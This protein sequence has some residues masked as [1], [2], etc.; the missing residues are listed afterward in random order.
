MAALFVLLLI[1]CGYDYKCRRIPNRLLAIM[2]LTCLGRSLWLAGLEGT[3]RSLPG[4]FAVTLVLYPLFKIGTMG[5]GDVKLFGI[6]TGF[7]PQGKIFYFVFFSMLIAAIFSL[8]KLIKDHNAR[9]RFGYFCEYLTNVM[10]TGRWKLYMDNEKE[11]T[12]AGICL[13]GPILCSMLLC[14]GGVY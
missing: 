4:M 7:L 6:C 11:R 9:E 8:F 10:C 3:A 13:A 5:A 1:A 12:A 14:W 2:L